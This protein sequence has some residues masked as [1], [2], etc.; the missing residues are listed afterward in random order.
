MR[1]RI[2]LVAT[3]L[4]LCSGIIVGAKIGA[5]YGVAALANPRTIQGVPAALRAVTHHPWK[6]A[7]LGNGFRS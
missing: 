4:A 6:R 5:A 1:V 7:N 3:V 2:L